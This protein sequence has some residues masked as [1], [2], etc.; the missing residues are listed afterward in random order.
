MRP[1]AIVLNPPLLDLAA[2]VVHRDEDLLIEA[3]LAQAAVERLDEGI[4]NVSLLKITSQPEPWTRD[5]GGES[6]SQR[7]RLRRRRCESPSIVL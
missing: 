5:E 1:L 3:L 6:C 7:S 4:L 2:R